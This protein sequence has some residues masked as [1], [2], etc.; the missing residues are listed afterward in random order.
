MKYISVK[1]FVGFLVFLSANVFSDCGG[2]SCDDV[3]IEQVYVRA[4]GP[5]L[6]QT[7]GNESL[8]S[9]SCAAEGGKWIEIGDTENKKDLLSVLLVAQTT[10]VSTRIR[11][12]AAPG[13]PCRISHV[14]LNKI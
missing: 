1:L 4:A 10:Q 12:T 5:H 11:I 7:S 13:A 2:T 8:L 9:S 6:V 3:V 14:E